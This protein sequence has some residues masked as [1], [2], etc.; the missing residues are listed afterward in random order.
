M[1]DFNVEEIKS[2]LCTLVDK[3]A[4]FSKSE[5]YE[6]FKQA[7]IGLEGKNFEDLTDEEKQPLV[8]LMNKI[9]EGTL[10]MTFLLMMLNPFGLRDLGKINKV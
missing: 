5:D 7:M 4:E 1:E 9:P 10:W 8:A 3:A 6:K 2:K